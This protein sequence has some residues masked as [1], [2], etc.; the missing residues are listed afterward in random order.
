[1][2]KN[3][4]KKLKPTDQDRASI[5]ASSF[6]AAAAVVAAGTSK[7]KY[8]DVVEITMEL[9]TDFYETRLDWMTEA[10]I[11]GA[12]PKASSGGGGGSGGRSGG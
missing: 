11:S 2:G 8:D 12:N 5:A 4:D 10:G 9:A 6:N 7:G 3:K 1:M